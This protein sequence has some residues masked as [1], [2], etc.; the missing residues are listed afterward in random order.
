MALYRRFYV[1]KKGSSMNKASDVLEYKT[2]EAALVKGFKE[3]VDLRTVAKKGL[4]RVDFWILLNAV[5]PK[6]WGEEAEISVRLTI[7]KHQLMSD[8][9]LKRLA[10]GQPTMTEKEMKRMEKSM[11]AHEKKFYAEQKRRGKKL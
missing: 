7:N 5:G 1:W 9:A 2:F 11:E 10:T 3:H 8:R 6:E 4:K